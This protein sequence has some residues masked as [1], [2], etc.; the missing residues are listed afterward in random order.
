MEYIFTSNKFIDTTALNPS[1]E[2]LKNLFPD[3]DLA[4]TKVQ[5][6]K[7]SIDYYKK[8]P[9]FIREITDTNSSSY[10]QGY[11]FY[12]VKDGIP[13]Q[14]KNL[15][16]CKNQ[17]DIDKKIEKYVAEI[18]KFK[19]SE[20]TAFADN[21]QKVMDT[22]GLSDNALYGDWLSAFGEEQQQFLIHEFKK[23]YNNG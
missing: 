6:F 1:N 16:F 7:A 10:K 20:M 4:N 22:K 14:T 12:F 5:Q 8:K 9:N 23:Y 21:L 13:N 15:V 2:M 17:E 3:T 18:E 19:S 11:R